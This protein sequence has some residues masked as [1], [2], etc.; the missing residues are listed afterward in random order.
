MLY[1]AVYCK[2]VLYFGMAL[3]GMPTAAELAGM[4]RAGLLKALQND[5][6]MKAKLVAINGRAWAIDENDLSQ[7]I[8]RRGYAPGAGR[9]RGAKNKNRLT[10][11]E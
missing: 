11:T 7:W 6:M 2:F 10:Q 4:S 1:R 8:K 9:P 5:E 3:L